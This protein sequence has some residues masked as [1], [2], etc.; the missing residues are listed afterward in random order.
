MSIKIMYA[1][2][3][4]KSVETFDSSKDSSGFHLVDSSF[5]KGSIPSVSL[6]SCSS[7]FITIDP[8]SS[9]ILIVARPQ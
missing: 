4:G 8:G 1:K 9:M 7:S 6:S 5:P 2:A 3:C